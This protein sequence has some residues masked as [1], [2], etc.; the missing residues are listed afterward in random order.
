MDSMLS[1]TKDFFANATEEEKQAIMVKESGNGDGDDTRGYK[2][3][4]KAEGTYE[5]CC[6]LLEQGRLHLMTVTLEGYR[7]PS[8]T[9]YPGSAICTWP[10]PQSMAE[11]TDYSQVFGRGLHRQSH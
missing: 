3:R 4:T 5:V 11:E 9:R 2:G 8:R 1:N 7:L 6:S 10:G